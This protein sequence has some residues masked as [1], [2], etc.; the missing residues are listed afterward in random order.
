[1]TVYFHFGLIV[2]EFLDAVRDTFGKGLEFER[3]DMERVGQRALDLI[4]A[5]TSKGMDWHYS[6]FVPYSKAYARH[7]DRRGRNT[8]PVDLLFTGKML[9]DM[10]AVAIPDSESGY[11]AQ[12]YFPSQQQ[13]QIAHYH[14]ATL[15]ED[16]RPRT[17]I[18]LRRFLAIDPNGRDQ[19]ILN[20]EAVDALIRRFNAS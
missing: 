19:Q 3:E 17:K 5:R 16:P 8:T 1:M 7:R 10:Q 18:P 11:I 4:L 9:A 14:N 2:D 15:D 6:Q 12:L 20:R 13:G